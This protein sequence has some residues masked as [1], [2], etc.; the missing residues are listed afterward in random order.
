MS[1]E[2]TSS[3]KAER[4]KGAN[5]QSKATKVVEN[6][7]VKLHRFLPSGRTVWTVVG[8][9]TDLLVAFDPEGKRKE[10]CSCDDFHFRVLGGRIPE[11]YHLLAAKQ[12]FR[13]DL[14]SVVEFND[15]EMADFMKALVGDIF[16]NL[17]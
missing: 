3:A 17:T 5:R 1:G 13:Q 9:E 7:G 2:I 4:Q 16:T 6:Q 11:C 12:A 14:Y 8:S 15:D 10:Y